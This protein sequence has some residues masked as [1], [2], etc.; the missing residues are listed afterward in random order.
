MSEKL[1]MLVEDSPDDEE[2]T[3]RALRQAKIANEIVVARDGAEA[4]DFLFGEGAY[5]GRDLSRMP[6]VFL[7]VFEELG[8]MP[9]LDRW[10][11]RHVL[12]PLRRGCRIPCFTIN[13]SG[14]TLGDELFP[15]FVAAE[16]KASGVPPE[17][18][19]FEFDEAD[20]AAGMDRASAAATA[21]QLTGCRILIDSFGAT[22]HSL[23]HLKRLR[24]DLVKI[25]GSI[26]RKLLSGNG[27]RNILDAILRIARTLNIGVIGSCVEQQDVLLRLK[28]LGVG[29]AQGFGIHE[30][31][32]LEKIAG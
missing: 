17:S 16:L 12:P 7:P 5:A 24:V 26:V 18:L 28:A 19:V 3:T 6:A 15:G 32:P 20:L 9:Q 30:P 31:G 14:Q 29:Y 2:L 27:A 4:V 21:L 22:A 10:V 13:L 1:I 11:V 25:D 23:A 8:M